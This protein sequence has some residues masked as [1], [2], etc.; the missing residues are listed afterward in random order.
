M[1]KVWVISVSMGYGHQRTAYPLKDL[2]PEGEVINANA[3]QGIP[4]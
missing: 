2:A 1:Q 3:Y 4:Q